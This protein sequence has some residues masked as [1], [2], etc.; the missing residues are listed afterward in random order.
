MSK[1]NM[2]NYERP[3]VTE[4]DIVSQ[5]LNEMKR[6][7]VG[8]IKIEPDYYS[9]IPCGTKVRY[10]NSNGEFRYGGVLVKNASP[11]YFVLRNIVKKMNWSVNLKKNY[12]YIE[13]IKQKN[14]E[15]LE[16]ENLYKLYKAGMV[17]VLDEPEE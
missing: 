1:E 14:K 9:Y 7:M 12:I 17:K 3:Q 11:D 8:Y 4:Q 15:K 2:D 10:I 6:L 5:D 16:K 13:D